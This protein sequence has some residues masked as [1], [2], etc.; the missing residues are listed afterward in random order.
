MKYAVLACFALFLAIGG[1]A[2]WWYWAGPRAVAERW[3]Q[4]GADRRAL[5]TE[6]DKQFWEEENAPGNAHLLS[7]TEEACL[8]ER[9]IETVNVRGLKAVVKVKN[10][11][12]SLSLEDMTEFPAAA[13]K[14]ERIALLRER[15]IQAQGVSEWLSEL[16]LVLE[17][18]RWRIDLNL[19]KRVGLERQFRTA[20]DHRK[21][22]L[23]TEQ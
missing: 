21:K 3:I 14:L 15:A 16:V 13:T 5:V 7:I 4:C 12:P 10:R 22:A 1:G 6:R 18:L 17:Q 2:A 23:S 9:V 19:E 11:R 20:E 8:G